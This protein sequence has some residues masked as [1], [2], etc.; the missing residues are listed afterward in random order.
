MVGVAASAFHRDRWRFV[1]PDPECR[2]HCIQMNHTH[3]YRDDVTRFICNE[4]YT[5]TDELYDK[6]EGRVRSPR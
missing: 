4:C 1:C 2:S 3:R 6:R 5:K